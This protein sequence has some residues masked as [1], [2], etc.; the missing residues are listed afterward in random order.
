M[1]LNN[2]D[3]NNKKVTSMS[4]L[5]RVHTTLALGTLCSISPA[6]LAQG[7]IEDSKATLTSRNY[8]FDRDYK[9]DS[10]QSATREWAQGFILRFTSGYTPGTVGFGLDAQ[11]LLGLKLDSSPDRTGTG[12]LPYD[13]VT[14]EPNDSYS[15]LGLTA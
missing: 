13:P 8:Y 6:L 5:K 2:L 1:P 14:R 15:K 3:D 12:L 9:G 10:A 7:F 4:T 11:G